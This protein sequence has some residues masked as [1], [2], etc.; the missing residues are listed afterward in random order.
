MALQRTG[1]VSLAAGTALTSG[2][3]MSLARKL[4]NLPAHR[5][6]RKAQIDR[7]RYMLIE[8]DRVAPTAAECSRIWGVLSTAE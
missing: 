5:V 3:A 2:S 4:R 6:A 8:Q 7:T 1:S